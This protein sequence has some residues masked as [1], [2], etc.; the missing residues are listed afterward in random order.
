M[1][2]YSYILHISVT[3]EC[4]Q[5]NSSSIIVLRSSFKHTNLDAIESFRKD[6]AGK[7]SFPDFIIF[8]KEI[9]KGCVATVRLVPPSLAAKLEDEIKR[10]NVSF[11]EQHNVLELKIQ[12]SVVYYA[13][14]YFLESNNYNVL[15]TLSCSGMPL[16]Y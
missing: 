8:L 6:L 3:I 2:I 14:K 16:L 11:L 13:S 4:C 15:C 5:Y 10:G 12:E 1:S 7:Y 9:K